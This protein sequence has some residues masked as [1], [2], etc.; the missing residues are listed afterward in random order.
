MKLKIQKDEI[1][2]ALYFIEN[3][4]AAGGTNI[5]SALKQALALK[6][7]EDERPTSIVFMTDGLPTEGETDIN[8]ILQNVKNEQ[9]EFV[10]ILHCGICS[11]RFCGLYYR[12]SL[13]K[14]LCSGC[15]GSFTV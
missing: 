1:Q 7:R 8:R 9:K 4:S 15:V 12:M 2:N 6:A 3:L 5:D 11:K 13:K 10:R 14:E